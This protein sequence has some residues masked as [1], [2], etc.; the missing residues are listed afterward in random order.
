MA[1]PA[2]QSA[3]APPDR[4]VPVTGLPHCCS[5]AQVSELAHAVSSAQKDKGTVVVEVLVRTHPLRRS[6]APPGHS[7]SEAQLAGKPAC[8]A[9]KYASPTAVPADW[10]SAKNA[11]SA[12]LI[13][14]HLVSPAAIVLLIDRDESTIRYSA[15]GTACA[16]EVW[17]TH[18]PPPSPEP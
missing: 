11:V 12:V 6:Q 13:A 14:S 18:P 10:L 7:P 4:Q 17:G 2:G 15:S 3:G 5:S 9:G 16:G 8:S 1:Q